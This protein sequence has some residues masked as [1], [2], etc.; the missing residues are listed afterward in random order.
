M[1]SQRPAFDGFAVALWATGTSGRAK[2]L[3]PIDVLIW[4]RSLKERPVAPGA[5]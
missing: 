1:P 2:G 5:A 3:V 4:S